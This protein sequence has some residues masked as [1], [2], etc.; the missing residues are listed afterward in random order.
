MGRFICAIG[1]LVL[2]LCVVAAAIAVLKRIKEKYLGEV[3]YI[4]V[5]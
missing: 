1:K 4:V 2:F 5:R 3:K